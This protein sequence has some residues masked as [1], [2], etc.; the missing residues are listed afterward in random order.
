MDAPCVTPL[1]PQ[2]LLDG[3]HSEV[4]DFKE[5][6]DGGTPQVS[7][8]NPHCKSDSGAGG[9]GARAVLLGPPPHFPR[10]RGGT[11]PTTR[12]DVAGQSRTDLNIVVLRR[13]DGHGP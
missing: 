5:E 12:T 9:G 13:R 8:G 2:E 11:R 10:G 6:W 3:T 1:T 7:V 4:R